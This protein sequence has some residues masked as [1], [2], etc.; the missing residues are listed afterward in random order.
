M[1]RRWTFCACSSG[2]S[3][4]SPALVLA[5]YRDDELDRGHPLRRTLGELATSRAVR[6][7]NV[8]QLSPAAVAQLAAPHG[9]DADELYRTTAGNP[10]FVVEALASEAEQIPPTVMDA[11]L[12]RAARRTS[13]ARM[14][15]EAAAVVPQHAEVWLLE[16]LAGDAVANLDE[17]LASGMLTSEPAGVMF[18]HEL[19]R[20]AVEQSLAPDRRLELHRK[21]LAALVDP[22]HGGVDVARLAH[23]ADAAQ[24]VDAVLEYAPAAARRAAALGAYRE[25]ADQYARALRFGDRLP[26][27]DRAELLERRADACYV[28]DQY[29]EGIAALEEALECRRSLR[30][31]LKE[32]DDLRRLSEFL[33][34]PGR[35]AESSSYAREAVE[36]LED[37][38]PGRE[39]AMAYANLAS[40]C[41]A[42]VR[43]QEAIAWGERALRLAET[44]GDTDTAV[45]ALGIIAISKGDLGQLEE[46]LELALRTEHQGARRPHL[47]SA[48]N[49]RGRKSQLNRRREVHRGKVLRT[50][51]SAASS[52]SACTFW[53]LA[54]DIALDQGRWAD[55]ADFA[56]SVLQHPSHLDGAPYCCARRARARPRAPR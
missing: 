41:S 6:R 43:S 45:Y 46:T 2:K 53:R 1:R 32:G 14:L 26:P 22:P 5:T 28:T 54:H 37:L 3:R 18:R 55:A 25:A 16:A 13:G 9:V 8:V 51:A 20:L 44:I 40:T 49:C 33:W 56:A 12:A 39:L 27:A 29:D 47:H 21:A 34:C 35:T 17:C 10:F 19:A 38:P 42:D 50:A 7:V 15:L 11:V 48:G 4:P 36:L 30:E 23:H 24:D 31:I 52:C